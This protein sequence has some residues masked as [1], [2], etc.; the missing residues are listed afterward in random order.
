MTAGALTVS[1]LSE[2]CGKLVRLATRCEVFRGVVF[3]STTLRARTRVTEQEF[4]ADVWTF[5]YGEESMRLVT[6]QW[7]L[8]FPSWL[9]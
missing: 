6:A 4:P 2:A 9:C 1:N 8:L 3:A 7:P 5:A